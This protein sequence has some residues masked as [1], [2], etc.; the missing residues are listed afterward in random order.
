MTLDT[1]GVVEVLD[2]REPKGSDEGKASSNIDGMELPKTQGDFSL[3]VQGRE[4][5]DSLYNNS[6]AYGFTAF[7][8][9]IGALRSFEVHCLKS[10]LFPLAQMSTTTS[11]TVLA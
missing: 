6:T 4:R 1:E 11:R 3:E 7:R 5:G 2:V 8:G 9:Q 10:F